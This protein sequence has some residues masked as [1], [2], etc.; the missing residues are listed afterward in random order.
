MHIEN[1]A[2]L[3][4]NDLCGPPNSPARLCNIGG[5]GLTAGNHDDGENA[6]DSRVTAFREVSQHT[7]SPTINFVEA[8]P[9][10]PNSQ[11]ITAS[12]ADAADDYVLWYDLY[13][14]MFNL[15]F[16]GESWNFGHQCYPTIQPNG[17]KVWGQQRYCACIVFNPEPQCFTDFEPAR[18]NGTPFVTSNANGVP[19]SV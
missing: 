7:F 12:I 11:G 3:T 19:D 14:G 1:L 9:G 17:A 8:S 4:Y 2:N 5:V 10:G 15:Q 13:A 18:G 16:S 6:G